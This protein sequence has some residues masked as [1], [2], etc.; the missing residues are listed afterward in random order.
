MEKDSSPQDSSSS[1]D[2][3]T[4]MLV[5]DYEAIRLLL[6]EYL[7][8][9]GYC[10][11]QARDGN[12]A[13]AIAKKECQNLDLI[14]MDVNMPTTDGMTATRQIRKIAELCHVPIV[15]CT[16][17]SAEDEREEV[18]AAGFNELVPKPLD[19]PTMKSILD[20][21]LPETPASS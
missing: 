21:Y 6:K 5:D 17:R 11:L 19:I 1:R 2:K 16:G 14:L 15:A 12:E 10:V 20:R 18:L 7:E 8:K 3:K 13:V 9:H 4:I